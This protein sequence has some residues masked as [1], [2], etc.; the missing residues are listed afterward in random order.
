MKKHRLGYTRRKQLAGIAFITPWLI[1]C[2]YFLV[3]PLV[4]SL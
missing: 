3:I 1:G 4:K 2:V